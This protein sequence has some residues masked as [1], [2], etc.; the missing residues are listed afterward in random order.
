MGVSTSTAF[1]LGMGRTTGL[2]KRSKGGG[3]RGDGLRLTRM[4]EM[5]GIVE[6][7]VDHPT[8]K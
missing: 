3:G 4:N 7:R 5:Q 6:K 2:E 1:R 8:M